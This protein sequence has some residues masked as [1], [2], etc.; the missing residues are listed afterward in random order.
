MSK[1]IDNLKS[2]IDKLE[3]KIAQATQSTN[4]RLKRKKIRSMKRD[5][6]KAIEKL[7]ESEKSFEWIESRI[8]KN[9]NSKRS[10]SKR[11]ENKIAEL[12]KKIRR[13][14]NKKNKERLIA[15]R[16]SLK[17]ELSWG[18]KKLE[19]AFGGA[20]RRYRIYGIEG[21]GH[22]LDVDTYFARTRKFLIDLLNKET[23]NRAM[24]SQ[25]TV[26]IRFVRGEVEQVSLAFNSRM[27]TVY[28]LNDKSEIVTAMI[29]HMAQQIENPA[30][31]NSKFVFDRVLHIDI[32][33]H[34]LNLTRGSSYVPLPDWLMKKKA[35]INPKNS[36]MECFKWA[37]IAAMKWE[38]IGNNPE[39]VS[40][41]RRYEGDFD[42]SDIEFPVSFRDINKFERNNEIGVNIL[43]VENKK[44][45]ICRKGKDYDRIV[46]LML[47]A[48]VENLNRKH[49]VAVK[50]LSRLLLKQNSKHKEAQHFCTNCLNGF[51][52]E[53]IRDEH[54]EYC[55][56]KDS[57]R[58]EMPTKNPIVKYADGQ[59]QFKVPFV[60]YADFESILVPV[61]G[62]PNNPEISST[63]RTN[64]HQPSGWCMYSKFAYG[65]VTNPLKQYRG[66]DCVSKFCETIIVEAKRLYESAP[67][68]PMDKLTK[69]QTVEFVTA[70]ENHIYFK[71]F[72]PKDRKV[73][74][75]CHYTG[76]YRGAAHSSCNL[77][78]RIPNYIPVVF[79]SLAGYDAHL[80]IRVG[81]TYEQNRSDS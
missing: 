31:R 2:Q 20:Y 79:H 40:K 76:K 44:T 9:N 77:R 56:S 17:M 73:R 37:V 60:I 21:K 28:N 4:A 62:V 68:K 22:V 65:K 81:K 72:S 14:K 69:E 46:N 30:L 3:N 75:H 54:Y 42:W 18:P 12:N 34:R 26:W 48:D 29:E 55:R 67:K 5:V 15:K 32:D 51:E 53:I 63:R 27:M 50:S 35:I 49:Y 11:I 16:N 23:T 45:Y 13:A 71:K 24:R 36:D 64:V 43:A 47:I 38:E 57:V 59:Y 70:K 25:A 10:S 52:S 6:V 41:L 78:Y 33:F 61:S 7:K 19:G 58:V 8:P 66:R 1:E 39:R 74:D 80:F